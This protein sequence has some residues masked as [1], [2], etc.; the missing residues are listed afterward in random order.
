[1]PVMNRDDNGGDVGGYETVNQFGKHHLTSS[2]GAGNGP[3]AKRV[4]KERK[5]SSRSSKDLQ[6]QQQCLEK[7]VL[8][9]V[10]QVETDQLEESI[11]IPADSDLVN[12]VQ[13]EIHIFFNKHDDDKCYCQDVIKHL[14]VL[15]EHSLSLSSRQLPL[16]VYFTWVV[17]INE[18]K[19]YLPEC[20]DP[21]RPS[22]MFLECAPT[23]SNPS[24][25]KCPFAVVRQRIIEWILCLQVSVQ[26]SLRW[27]THCHGFLSSNHF[28]LLKGLLQEH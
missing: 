18:R 9:S 26:C 25:K 1:M 8:P 2:R 21:D 11:Q 20:L 15:L 6:Q 22:I 16:N 4:H 7:A 5:K 3:S 23:R 28:L 10:E 19:Y 14:K 24:C 17:K 27:F 13:E 12:L